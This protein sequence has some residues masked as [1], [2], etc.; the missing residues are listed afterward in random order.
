MGAA[1]E[2]VM[3]KREK[4]EEFNVIG[5]APKMGEEEVRMVEEILG[6]RFINKDLV[7]EAL[8]HGSFYLPYKPAKSYE[9]LEFMGDA[10]LTCIVAREVFSSYPD[11]SPGPLTRLRA[12]NVDTEKLARVAVEHGLHRYLRHK[13]PQLEAQIQ[14]FMQAMMEY[15]IHSNGLVDPPKVLADIVES[16]LGAVFL[17]TSSSLETVCEIFRRLAAPLINPETLG[18]HPMSEL[19]ELCQKLKMDVTFLKGVWPENP[20]IEVLVDGKLVGSGNG[21]K[22]EIA[23]NRAAKAALDR[24]KET[25]GDSDSTA[26]DHPD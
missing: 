13:A 18:K 24:L 8:T 9:R 4:R 22:K 14:D 11:L 12:A 26:L 2:E 6:Y 21:Q 17:D 25:L 5:T 3:G 10:V 7:E 20:K 1:D 16:L 15:P 23:Q 19:Y